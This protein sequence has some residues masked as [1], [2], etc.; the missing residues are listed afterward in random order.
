MAKLRRL[1]LD[2]LKPHDPPLV[3]FTDQVAETDSVEAVTASLIELDREVQNCKLTVEGADVSLDAVTETIET[4][5]GSV[6]SVDEVAC[7]EHVVEDRP[8]HQDD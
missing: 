7:G 3:S 6:H 4:I 5:G 2:V 1:V 8:T